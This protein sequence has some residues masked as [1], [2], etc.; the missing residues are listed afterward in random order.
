MET[1]IPEELTSPERETAM[2]LVMTPPK[3]TGATVAKSPP[4]QDA[5][6]AELTLGNP[7]KLTDPEKMERLIFLKLERAVAGTPVTMPWGE[8]VTMQ[9]GVMQHLLPLTTEQAKVVRLLV[10]R[11]ALEAQ[12]RQSPPPAKPRSASLLSRTWRRLR[13]LLPVR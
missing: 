2:A 9:A 13:R 10:A 12:K 5:E 7:L 6:L 11:D 4:P 3:V 1:R 8:V